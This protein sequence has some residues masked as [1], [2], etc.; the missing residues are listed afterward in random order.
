MTHAD[1]QKH[2]DAAIKASRALLDSLTM[3]LDDVEGD[4]NYDGWR[5]EAQRVWDEVEATDA[6]VSELL[7]ALNK[8]AK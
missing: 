5:H 1:A 7:P 6:T 3:A 4:P 8:E 2:I